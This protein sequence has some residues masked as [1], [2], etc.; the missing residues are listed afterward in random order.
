[1]ASWAQSRGQARKSTFT[2]IFEEGTQNGMA[3]WEVLEHQKIYDPLRNVVLKNDNILVEDERL[4][5]GLT[6]L[7]L[8]GPFPNSPFFDPTNTFVLGQTYSSF[9]Y[10]SPCALLFCNP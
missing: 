8:Q 9:G 5:I 2:V 3:K 4:M 1:M 6:K 10:L 7:L